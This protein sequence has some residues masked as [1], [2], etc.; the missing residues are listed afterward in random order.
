M[1]LFNKKPEYH[2][3]EGGTRLEVVGESHYR[4]N[5]DRIAEAYQAPGPD[6]SF[7]VI[8]T[9]EPEP[10][11]PHDPNAVAVKVLGLKVG[12]LPANTA[13]QYQPAIIRLATKH[14]A[15]IA[16][17]GFLT[18]GH[19]ELIYSLNLDHDPADFT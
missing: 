17:R 7:G 12:H 14:R 4:D 18:T 8:A 2:L 1:R 13:A 19:G 10:N 16:V 3:L 11:N 5:F 9:L 6:T 15:P